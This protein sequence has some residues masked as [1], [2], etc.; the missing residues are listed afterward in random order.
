M[1][2]GECEESLDSIGKLR[3]CDQRGAEQH[4]ESGKRAECPDG[5]LC[6]ARRIVR[7]ECRAQ[8]LDEHRVRLTT[9]GCAG[10]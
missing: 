3:A 2:Y 1:A 5:A 6:G 4:D 9:A 8:C 10:R 7:V